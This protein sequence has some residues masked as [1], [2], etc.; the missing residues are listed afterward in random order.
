LQAF[1]VEVVPSPAG[2][3]CLK[4]KLLLL[5][6]LLLP[7]SLLLLAFLL[8]LGCHKLVFDCMVHGHQFSIDFQIIKL[9]YFWKVA[10]TTAIWHRCFLFHVKN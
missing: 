8:L 9:P 1:A 2:V 5:G 6:S 3:P 7:T 10:V 4:L